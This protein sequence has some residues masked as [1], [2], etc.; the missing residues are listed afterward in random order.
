MT[1]V[2]R[3][4]Y[5][6]DWYKL[7]EE[8][9]SRY[10]D[11][12]IPSKYITKDGYRLGRW[13]ERQ[14]KAYALHKINNKRYRKLS[15]IHMVWKLENRLT[16]SQWIQLCKDY[17]EIHHNLKVPKVYMINGVNLGNWIIAQKNKYYMGLLNKEQIKELEDIGMSWVK[18]KRRKWEYWYRIAQNYF[19]EHRNLDVQVMYC[20]A[21][22]ERLGQWIM[23]QRMRYKGTRKPSLTAIQIEELN[24]L[25][26]IWSIKNRKR[27]KSS[28]ESG[29]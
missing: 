27:I 21:E 23:I 6:D 19:D 5:W 3:A 10:G 18:E 17:F 14:R 16:R 25:G 9:Y 12:L 26:M 29:Y 4:L 1:R 24:R 20:T 22:G 2:Y 15:K 8:Y 11:L 13:I 7:A 28:K